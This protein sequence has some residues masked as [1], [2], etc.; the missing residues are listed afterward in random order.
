MNTKTLQRTVNSLVQAP[1]LPRR[2]P[3]SLPREA[4]RGITSTVTQ[5]PSNDLSITSRPQ[6]IRK[7]KLLKLF[8]LP[9]QQNQW[10]DNLPRPLAPPRVPGAPW[11][12]TAST[13]CAADGCKVRAYSEVTEVNYAKFPNKII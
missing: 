11:L 4:L 13:M 5:R 7:M 3:T 10:S 1:R 12:F 9:S 8:C 6:C 2:S